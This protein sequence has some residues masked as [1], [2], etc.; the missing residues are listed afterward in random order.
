MRYIL[1]L[2]LLVAATAAAEVP[3]NLVVDGV[4]DPAPALVERVAPYLEARSASLLDWNPDRQ[5]MLI[6]TRFGDAAQIHVVKMAGGARKQLTFYAEPVRGGFR[7]H[8]ADTIL[9]AKD[10]GGNEQFQLY[11]MDVPTGEVTLLTDGKSRNLPGSWSRDGK[12]LAYGSNQRS[13]KDIDL[14]VIDL[15]DPKSARIVLQN[16]GGGWSATDFS[17]DGKKM[18][19]INRVSATD[20]NLYLLDIASGTKTLLTPKKEGEEVSYSGANFSADDSEIFFTTDQGSEFR[21]LVRMNLAK[22]TRTVVAKEPWDV[23]DFE[24]SENR[25]LLVYAINENGA[26]AL[27][28]VDLSTGKSLATPKL[29]LGVIGGIRWHPKTDLLGFS[30]ASAKSPSDVYSWDYRK[31]EL[32]RWTESET[33]GLNPDRNAEPERITFASFDGTKISALLYRPDAKK[34]PGKRPVI[35]NI[36]GGPEGQSRAGFIGRTNYWI[37]ELGIAVVFPNVRGSTGYGKTYLAADNGFKRE[38]SVKDIGALLD[39]IGND[40]ALDANRVAVYGGSYGG[41]MVLASMVHFHERL[42]AAVDVVGISNFLTFLK[43]TSGYR[44]DLRRVE[45]GDERDEAMR[46]HLEK[47]SPM[48]SSTKIDKP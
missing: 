3:S 23:S 30:L 33:G 13:A 2:A 9:F 43:N 44:V 39:W 29:P 1:A 45:Y 27:R 20:S 26:D 48:N 7:P 25:K 36:H 22:G 37:N 10:T 4:P 11:R 40:D 21:Q 28:L 15:S 41:Y 16:E 8:H 12:W 19:V 47:I 6:S 31:K 34:F 18:L 17:A 24:L 5:E 14:W 46:A 32:V 38:D 42:R 35:V